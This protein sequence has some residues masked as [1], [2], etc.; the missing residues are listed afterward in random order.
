MEEKTPRLRTFHCAWT[1]LPSQRVTMKAVDVN[2]APAKAA[3][4]PGNLFSGARPVVPECSSRETAA[5]PRKATKQADMV[6]SSKG[7]ER[8]RRERMMVN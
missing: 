5:N 3:M 7:S 1:R 2:M 4:M 6:A 8:N